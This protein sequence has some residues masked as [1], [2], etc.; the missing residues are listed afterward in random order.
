MRLRAAIQAALVAAVLAA[1]PARAAQGD[2][3][4]V[5]TAAYPVEGAADAVISFTAF[6]SD[7]PTVGQGGIAVWQPSSGPERRITLECVFVFDSFE[8]GHALFAS[9]V[10]DDGAAY[11]LAVHQEFI[12]LELSALVATAPDPSMPCGAPRTVPLA[13]GVVQFVL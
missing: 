5:G 3:L 10:G 1:A 13:K 12:L 2:H 9:G 8:I 4:A 7:D 6:E 11:Y